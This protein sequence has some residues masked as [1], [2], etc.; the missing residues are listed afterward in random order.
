MAYSEEIA[1]EILGVIGL[2]CVY[3]RRGNCEEYNLMFFLSI[4][5][6]FV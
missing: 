1:N 5:G 6:Y 2:I 3:L 4:A